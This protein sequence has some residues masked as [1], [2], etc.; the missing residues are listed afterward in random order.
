MSKYSTIFIGKISSR[1][2]TSDI[3]HKFEKYGR[4]K[5]I[6]YRKDRGFAFV[7]YSHWEDAKYAI[8]NGL[9]R[10]NTVHIN[11]IKLPVDK[12]LVLYRLLIECENTS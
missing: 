11:W 12:M 5:E 8:K 1:V 4:I 3:E 6:D 2:H 7:E 10:A 9:K